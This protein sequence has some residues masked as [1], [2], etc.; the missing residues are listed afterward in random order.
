MTSMQTSPV[1]NQAAPLP[2]AAPAKANDAPSPA[3][4]FNQVL[5]REIAG[6]GDGA[7]ATGK[8]AEQKEAAA[9]KPDAVDAPKDAKPAA[10]GKQARAADED[11]STDE[12]GK[13]E[14]AQQAPTDIL[15]LVASLGALQQQAADSDAAHA[16]PADEKAAATLKATMAG[17]TPPALPGAAPTVATPGMQSDL[18][19]T[20]A[21]AGKRRTTAADGKTATRTGLVDAD[22]SAPQDGRA[23]EAAVP[24]AASDKPVAAGTPEHSGA[25]AAHATKTGFAAELGDAKA[26]LAGIGAAVQSAA[27]AAAVMAQAQTAADRLSPRVGTPAWDQALGQKVVWMVAGEQQ[28]ASLTLNPPDLGPLQVVLNVSNATAHAS[29]TAA[30]PEVRQALEAALPRLREML[31]EAGIQLGQATV[32][33][34][35]PNQQQSFEQQSGQAAQGVRHA[36]SGPAADDALPRTTRVQPV[37]GRGLVDTFV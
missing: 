27:P 26:T 10:P 7:A 11:R 15:A 8:A 13:S 3:T 29:F 4:P 9:A 6:R 23:R 25:A 30:Q 19:A 14:A 32:G 28:S 35:S 22:A 5:S 37:V 16:L 20:Q 12:A 17:G 21:D 18:D 1:L 24:V 33:S 2:N 34:G 31:G 36:D